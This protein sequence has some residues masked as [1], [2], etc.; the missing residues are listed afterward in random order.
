ME[1][2]YFFTGLFMVSDCDASAIVQF[3]GEIIV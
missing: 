3:L 2:L 1:M